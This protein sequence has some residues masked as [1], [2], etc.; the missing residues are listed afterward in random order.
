MKRLLCN[1]YRS[2]KKEGMY[3]YLAKADK[4]SRVPEQLLTLFGQP[5]LAMTMLLTESKK[6]AEIE[7]EV[8]MTA[9]E[10]TGFYLQMPKVDD[11]YMNAINQHN[12]KLSRG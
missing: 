7:A 9:I 11:E 8:L 12:S 5:Q 3:L 4:L 10:T 1:V 6:L 2:P